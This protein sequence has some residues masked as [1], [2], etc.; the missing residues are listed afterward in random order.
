MKSEDVQNK[1]GED[2]SLLNDYQKK[3]IDEALDNIEK[4]KVLFHDEII[5]GTKKH[6]PHLFNR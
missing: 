6:F 5:E 4:R 2:E 3:A 1:N